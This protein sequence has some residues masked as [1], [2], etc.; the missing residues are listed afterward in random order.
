MGHVNYRRSGNRRF[1]YLTCFVVSDE[2][3]DHPILYLWCNRS[4]SSSCECV[5]RDWMETFLIYR[6]R[7]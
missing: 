3:E 5:N 1:L 7:Y 6:Q 2:I 4:D